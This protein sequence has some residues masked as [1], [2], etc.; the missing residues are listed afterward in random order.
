MNQQASNERHAM[1]NQKLPRQSSNPSVVDQASNIWPA[2]TLVHSLSASQ[3]RQLPRQ[4]TEGICDAH[5]QFIDRRQLTTQSHLDVLDSY[6]R[7]CPF[8]VYLAVLM[9]NGPQCYGYDVDS[10]CAPPSRRGP[11]QLTKFFYSFGLFWMIISIPLLA[12]ALISTYYRLYNKRRSLRDL[13]M[14][15]SEPIA[16]TTEEHPDVAKVETEFRR[17]LEQQHRNGYSSMSEAYRRA[18]NARRSRKHVSHSVTPNLDVRTSRGFADVLTQ[19]ASCQMNANRLPQPCQQHP[20]RSSENDFSRLYL[21][22]IKHHLL[23]SE[24]HHRHI[25]S[26]RSLSLCLALLRLSPRS[27]PPAVPQ[28]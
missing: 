28:S 22:Q 1:A 13:Q 6:R 10:F 15:L 21:S 25:I 27:L 11:V 17:W 19:R 12:V 24:K 14:L 5:T 26:L 4:S 23:I 2:D 16:R 18:L 7:R 9:S 8:P 20:A 3:M